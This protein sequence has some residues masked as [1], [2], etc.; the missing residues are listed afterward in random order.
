MCIKYFFYNKLVDL[1]KVE[2]YNREYILNYFNFNFNT[3]WDN[4]KYKECRCEG[5]N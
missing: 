3:K 1:T 2:F 4:V 5:K